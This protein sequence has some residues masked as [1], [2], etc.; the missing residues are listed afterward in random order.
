MK[1]NKFLIILCL[2]KLS[3]IFGQQQKTDSLESILPSV[4]NEERVEILHQL[5]KANWTTRPDSVV[6]YGRE[7]LRLSEKLGD[8]RLQSISCR[9]FGGLY[10]YMSLIDSGRYYKSKAL[11]IALQLNDSSLLPSTYNNLGVT[12]QTVGSYV[13]ALNYYYMAYLVSKKKSEVKSLPTILA[14]ISEVYYD[15]KEY[16]SAI[17]YANEAI[18]LTK[19]RTKTS[20]HLLAKIDLAKAM[21]ATRKYGEAILLFNSIIEIGNE[22]NLKRYVAYAY[23]GLGRL[24]NEIGEIK[25]SSQNMKQAHLLFTEL[26]DQAYIAETLSDF[27]YLYSKI[28]QDSALLFCRE[29]LKIAKE[30]R[31]TDIVLLNYGLLIQLYGT[32]NFSQDSLWSYYLKYRELESAQSKENN[33]N[34][35]EGMFSKIQEEDIRRQLTVSSAKLDQERIQAQFFIAFAVITILGIVLISIYYRKQRRL[36]YH[37]KS[38]NKL[39]SNQNEIIN[40]KNDDLKLLNTE[41]N[42]LIRIVAHDLKNPLANIINSAQLMHSFKDQNDQ[43]KPFLEIIETS[44]DRLMGMI[45]KILNVEAIEKGLSNLE[46][47]EVDLSEILYSVLDHFET[48]ANNKQIAI[49]SKVKNKI[50]VLAEPT[51]MYQVIENLI[52]NAIKFS[53]KG[54][55]IH[56]YLQT[57][58][59]AATIEVKDEGPGISEN[60]QKLMFKMFQ[61]LSAKPTGNESSTGVGLSI[62]KKYVD[63]MN[64]KIWLSSKLGNG[65]SFY[66]QFNLS[67]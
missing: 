66:L 51:Y 14:N 62:V 59:N 13:E 4:I 6:K 40:K 38:A 11:K 65:T 54:S 47:S 48:Q 33:L 28:D 9:L 53:P 49:K 3:D 27:G 55:D 32:N 46:L 58:N 52:S 7:A 10:N 42:N 67:K 23:Q 8:L 21:L 1:T 41:K 50:Q 2:F 57:N 15:L 45:S 5:I 26:G 35:I 30:I 19:N 12:S 24:N 34:S 20:Q 56:I 39:M 60:D 18:R 36:G 44:A 25:L 61:K 29:S 64:G 17:K 37:L 16:D 31:L 43:Q 22:V 63:A